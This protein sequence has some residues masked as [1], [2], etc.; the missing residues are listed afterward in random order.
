MKTWVA[1]LALVCVVAF[2]TGVFAVEPSKAT[3]SQMGISGMKV[4]TDAQGMQVRGKYATVS[5]I[6]WAQIGPSVGSGS[7]A[8]G[9]F[10]RGSDFA[11]GAAIGTVRTTGLFGVP[12]GGV[13][14]TGGS[15]AFAGR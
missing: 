7:Y 1:L 6:A 11:F 4:M 8:A 14:A 9:D 13:V 12:T 10:G 2:S 15:V 5:G 3:L